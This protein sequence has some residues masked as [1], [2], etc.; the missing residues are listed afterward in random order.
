MSEHFLLSMSHTWDFVH[1][2]YAPPQFLFTQAYLSLF[3]WLLD[4]TWFHT[5]DHLYHSL[6]HLP[7][8]LQKPPG[9]GPGHP[10]V[11]GPAETE[12]GQGDL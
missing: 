1:I 8:D 5:S 11:G 3:N 4:G 12:V 9:R 10:N 2:Q 7:G 6:L